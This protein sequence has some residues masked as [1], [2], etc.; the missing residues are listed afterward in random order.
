VQRRTVRFREMEYAVPVAELGPA[1][2]DIRSVI[3]DNGWRISF[4]IEVRVARGDDRWLSTASGRDSAYLAVHRYHREDP[5]DYF[6]AVE[7]R[8]LARGGRPHWGKEHT[9]DAAA[10]R[11]RYEH[12]DDFVTLRNRL[13][14]DRVFTNPYL[15]RVLGG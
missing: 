10:L 3:A 13:D 8:M 6:A 12:F 11:P 7:E 15:D 4:P 9:L 14:P 2:D 1:V 5:T